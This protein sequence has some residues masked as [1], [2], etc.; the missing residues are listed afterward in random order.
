MPYLGKATRHAS[1]VGPV[2]HPISRQAW[3]F[4]FLNMIKWQD[5]R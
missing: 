5:V 2:M 1:D 4:K 3:F